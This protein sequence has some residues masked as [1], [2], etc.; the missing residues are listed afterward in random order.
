L[1]GDLGR[2]TVT[3]LEPFSDGIMATGTEIHQGDRR[4]L[5]SN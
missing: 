4:D 2:K 1:L 5:D 3:V